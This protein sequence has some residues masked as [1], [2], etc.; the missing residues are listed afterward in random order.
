MF[1]TVRLPQC[2]A[3]DKVL[4]IQCEELSLLWERCTSEDSVVSEAC[5]DAI[6]ALVQQGKIDLNF[7]VNSLIN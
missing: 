2:C 3:V 6:L 5:C 7:A 4:C 1:V